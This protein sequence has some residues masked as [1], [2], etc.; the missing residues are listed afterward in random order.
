MALQKTWSC[1]VIFFLFKGYVKDTGPMVRYPFNEN[2]SLPICYQTWATRSLGR[3]LPF[4]PFPQ[5]SRIN[6]TVLLELGEWIA[7]PRRSLFKHTEGAGTVETAV[8]LSNFQ[9]YWHWIDHS[10]VRT[11][12]NFWFVSLGKWKVMLIFKW[13]QTLADAKCIKP[14]SGSGLLALVISKSICR[15]CSHQWVQWPL[16]CFSHCKHIKN[17]IVSLMCAASKQTI[18]TPLSTMWV[19]FPITCVKKLSNTNTIAN[20]VV[21]WLVC[22]MGK[23]I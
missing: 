7:N 22:T 21:L 13:Q 10:C 20:K 14:P 15:S 16:D 19:A 8:K 2:L 9:T 6:T 18:W 3:G 17:R 5:D 11:W 12:P 4:S 1:F 23:L